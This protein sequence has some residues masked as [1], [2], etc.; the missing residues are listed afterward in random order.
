MALWLKE[1]T[2]T[3]EKIGV[4]V[5]WSNKDVSQLNVLSSSH[6]HAVWVKNQFIVQINVKN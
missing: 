3:E 2:E 6:I 4:W 1:A 5:K